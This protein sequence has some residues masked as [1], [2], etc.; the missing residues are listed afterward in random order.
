MI[1]KTKVNGIPCVCKV[2]EYTPHIPMQVYGPNMA[3]A[4][5][6]ESEV[7]D[8]AILDRK[9]KPAP[10]LEKYVTQSVCDDL[11]EEFHILQLADYYVM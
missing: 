9:G 4:H 1:F 6:P 2:M 3:D 7:F 10:W 8:F 11:L 5:P